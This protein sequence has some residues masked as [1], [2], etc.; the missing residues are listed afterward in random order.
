MVVKKSTQSVKVV[1]LHEETCD[2]PKEIIEEVDSAP[3]EVLESAEKVVSDVI[4]VDE[5][6][7]VERSPDERAESPVLWEYKLPAPP[8]PF[9]DNGEALPL[10]EKLSIKS[11]SDRSRSSSISVDSLQ[12]VT[13]EL[14]DPIPSQTVQQVT[15]TAI[16]ETV[17]TEDKVTLDNGDQLM[18]ESSVDEP[19]VKEQSE[20]NEAV[21]TTQTERIPSP[22]KEEE[23]TA[24]EIVSDESLPS[25]IPPLPI[26][27][28]PELMAEEEIMIADPIEPPP[29]FQEEKQETVR[30]R[31]N[32][33]SSNSSSASLHSETNSLPA[34][35][36]GM[37]RVIT[38]IIVN[39][40]LN[41]V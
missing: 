34:T 33:H 2:S 39:L 18:G 20:E 6:P 26:T 12:E 17:Q 36:D 28:P 29:I 4:Q 16:I 1:N 31:S 25:I 19:A 32:S 23:P 10:A 30:T 13:V 22:L 9:A 7:E 41:C 5:E 35:S 27:S 40:T 8:T 3:S 38:L 15:T 37:L 21:E 11:D 14:D 24:E